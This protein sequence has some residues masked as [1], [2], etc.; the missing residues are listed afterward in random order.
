MM[1]AVAI[2]S[3][4][5]G[6]ADVK[7]SY[8]VSD[9]TGL[10]RRRGGVSNLRDGPCQKSGRGGPAFWI[11]EFEKPEARDQQ[12]WFGPPWP[13]SAE[14]DRCQKV[15]L[16]RPAA[17]AAMTVP[18]SAAPPRVRSSQPSSQMRG[19][20]LLCPLLGAICCPLL[21]LCACKDPYGPVSRRP[22]SR[23]AVAAILPTLAASVLLG[24]LGG[25]WPCQV[26][27]VQ[28]A[29]WPAPRR[30]WVRMPEATA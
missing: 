15:G 28:K 8:T 19:L 9:A 14:A 5:G 21:P 29:G 26:F 16:T 1:G 17:F 25:L 22:S 13:V 7:L 30:R 24:G 20:V 6:V 12:K 23:T 4:G 2:W 18:L 11:L 3:S 27:S 10:G